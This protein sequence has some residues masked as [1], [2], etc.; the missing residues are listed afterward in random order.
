MGPTGTPT[1]MPAGDDR[2]ARAAAASATPCSSRSAAALRAQ[3]N[4]VL[5]FAGYKKARGPLQAR[6]DRGG[7][8]PGHLERRPAASIPAAPPAGPRLRRATSSQAMLAYATRRARARSRSRCPT[9]ERI[10]A[11]GSR[12]HD[13]GGHATARHG[14]LAPHLRPGARRPSRRINS[15]M[16]CMM[17][18]VCAQCL[19]KHVDPVTGKE[20]SSSPASTRT[21]TS[22]TVDW[23]NL[24]ARLAPEHRAGEALE[25]VAGARA[26]APGSPDRLGRRAVSVA[27]SSRRS[28]RG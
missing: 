5:Y 8:R 20:T 21:R 15:P 12:P 3:G 24:R 27:G 22:T 16:Q 13:D 9:C 23:K 11:I 10:I 25:P 19:Q 26:L 18:E 2:A 17:K 1:E 14:V 4:R 6:R 28:G 7:H